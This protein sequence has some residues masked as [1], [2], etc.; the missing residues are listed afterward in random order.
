MRHIELLVYSIPPL[1]GIGANS[2]FVSLSPQIF[3]VE[4][5]TVGFF[6]NQFLSFD[7]LHVNIC[8]NYTFTVAYT[9]VSH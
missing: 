1:I 3:T 9:G 7:G 6:V 4:R 5:V 8:S 2:A